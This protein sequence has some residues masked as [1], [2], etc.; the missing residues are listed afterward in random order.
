MTRSGQPPE[1]ALSQA[2]AEGRLR[3][4]LRTVDGRSIDVIHRGTW[5]HGFGPDFRDALL[6]VDGRELRAGSVELHL[7]TAAWTA[8]G[9]AQDERYN[10]V[11]L[12]AVYEHDGNETRRQDG[13]LVPIVALTDFLSEPLAETPALTGDWSRFGGEVCAPELARQRPDQIRTIL[14]HLGDTRLA[15]KAARLEARLTA[16]PPGDV[17]YQELWDGLG[18]AHN[19]DPMRALA[20]MLPLA[21]V[22]SLLLTVPNAERLALARGLLFGAAGF[23]PLS[24]AD[25]AFALLT[26]D[27]TLAA[28]AQW[29]RHGA[30]WQ[31]QTL[32]P[33][34]W[35]RARVRPANH[36]AA[37]LAAGAALIA[38]AQG[39]LVAALLSPV[40]AGGD[41]V[42]A[43]RTL[44]GGNGQSPPGIGADRA[45]GL[46]ANALLPFAF[47]VAAHTGDVEL[48]DATALAWERL[49]A[50]E[51][52]EVTRRAQRQIAGAARLPGLAA[53]G[54][55]GL[56]HLDATLCA[57][58]RCYEC[59][60]AHRVLA[61]E[62][63]GAGDAAPR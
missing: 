19:R 1:L 45:N 4:P 3:G 51:P 48:T 30:P 60:I 31:G 28:E 61:E 58:R 18:F 37:R 49:P 15:A 62:S 12:H 55:Q 56:L 11:I 53:R 50:A 10:D 17:L 14:W 47:A 7:R 36:P 46:V 43:L 8:H 42:A 29:I 52:N 23:L 13:A 40:R 38:S 21:T 41:P 26:P 9:H 20:R 24:P 63:A 33:T 32:H 57:P 5:T 27:E 54:Q 59:P 34:A 25:A 44:A 39:G 22:E 16:E 2:W 35:T 6:L